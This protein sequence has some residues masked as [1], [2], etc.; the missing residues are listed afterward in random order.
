VGGG[1]CKFP[2]TLSEEGEGLGGGKKEP[3]WKRT[4]GDTNRS[5]EGFRVTSR[6]VRRAKIVTGSKGRKYVTKRACRQQ[7]SQN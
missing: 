2:R 6:K 4:V 1:N 3:I 7:E 5:G